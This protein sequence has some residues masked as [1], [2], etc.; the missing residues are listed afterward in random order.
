VGVNDRE[1][2]AKEPRRRATSA[3]VARESGVSRATVS[4][5]LNNA[6]DR[7][8][9][10]ATRALVL[11]TAERLGHVPYAPARALRSGRMNVVLAIVPGF[12]IGY[13]FDLALDSLNRELGNRGYAL[14]V[15]RM[16]EEQEGMNL[17]E[18]W[19]AVTPTL[20]LAM[21]GLPAYARRFIDVSQAP[22]VE[23]HGIISHVE[24]GRMQARFLHAAG[25]RRLAFGYPEDPSIDRYARQRLEGVRAV[26]AE[27]GI[28]PPLVESIGTRL[29]DVRAA[30]ERWRAQGVT[31]VC[32]HNDELALMV[33]AAMSTMGL[34]P[35]RELSVVGVDDIPLASIGLTTVAIATD[36]FTEAVVENVVSVLENRSPRPV[37]AP[38]LSMVVRT[39]TGAPP[40]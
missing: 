15:T 11:E 40:S 21:G 14:L 12:S 28:A 2:P 19:G 37:T 36:V 27:E 18:L 6:P 32:A 7:S 20:V 25:H 23:D 10:A 22:L 26:C 5:V 16:N 30:V 17:R 33:V 1:T 38:M 31:A 3:D 8:I 34:R 4:Y 35:G 9:S 24:T 13:V 29:D 39:S